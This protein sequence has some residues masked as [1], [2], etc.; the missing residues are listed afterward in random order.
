MDQFSAFRSWKADPFLVAA[1]LLTAFI[2][3]RGWR[4]LRRFAPKQ[5]TPARLYCFLGGL[6]VL[7]LAVASPLDAFAGFLLQVHMVQHLLLTMVVP[8]LLLLG[9]PYL[10]FLKGLPRIWVREV[11]GPFLNGPVWKTLGGFF[12]HPVVSWGLFIASN[13]IWHVPSFYDATLRSDGWHALE[14]ACFLGT[15]LI[16]WWHVVL[17]FPAHPLWPRWYVIPYLLLAD[18]QNT[19]LGAFL[20]FYDQPLY[21]AY[22]TVPRLWG[23][24]VMAD[25]AGAGAIM[26]VPGSI[27][28][29]LPAAIIAAKLLAG[30]G[31]VRPSEYLNPKAVIKPV[32]N[33]K[34]AD[35][36]IR[37]AR[38]PTRRIFQ[39]I[40]LLLAAAVV[41]DGFFGPPVASMNLAGVLTWTYWRG[42]SVLALLTL[43]NFFCSICPFVLARDVA[44]KVAP[45]GQKWQ[46]PKML[47][48][49]WSAIALLAAF[50]WAY[51]VFDLWNRPVWTAILIV[52]YFAA[53]IAIDVLFRGAS[54]CKYVCPIGQYHF[55]FAGSSSGEIAVSDTSVCASCRTHDCL[56]GNDRDRGCETHLFQPKKSGN[57]DCTFCLD[58]VR[59]C[60][61]DNVTLKTVV[62]VRD[63]ASDRFRSSVGEYSKRP[64]LAVLFGLFVAGAFLNAFGM[65]APVVA[66]ARQVAATLGWFESAVIALLLP[67]GIAVYALANWLA[68]AISAKFT[69]VPHRRQFLAFAAALTPLGAGMWAAHFLFHFAT[70]AFTIV[71]VVQRVLGDLGFKFAGSPDWTK[72]GFSGDWIVSMELLLLDAGLLGSLY[73]AWRIATREF[74]ASRRFAGFAPWA[75]L[76]LLL[77]GLAVWTMFQPMD[78]RG[79]MMSGH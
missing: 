38:T 29:L 3:I 59:A 36:F 37:I 63:L 46:W 54:F 25:Q 51:E 55:A 57:M 10:P 33:I 72:I 60:P 68:G 65:T 14:H 12:S 2:Y 73:V 30:R 11:I 43:G 75:V 26:W 64:D 40:L 28:F 58:C 21:P 27:A 45:F 67:A 34:K 20:S 62:P 79:T 50:L 8:P 70:G 76:I 15:S 39:I 66:W 17:P 19:A 41:L 78:M 7:F 24:T 9:A 49:K 56:R 35:W 22:A 74:A 6:A 23:I 18:F 4:Q 71:P 42:L 53:A 61:A 13:V 1:L 48:N 52:A 5:F 44:R 31:R 69:G 77:F 16:F 32:V 47:R